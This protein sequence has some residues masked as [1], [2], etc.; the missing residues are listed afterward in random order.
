MEAVPA[1]EETNL[2]QLLAPIRAQ[3]ERSAVLTDVDGTLAPIAPRPED[4]QVPDRAREL[5]RDLARRYAVIGC[6]SGRR[7]LDARR[8]VGLDELSYSG[9]HGFELLSPGEPEPHP[10]PALDGHE[11][12]A[13]AFLERVD[14]ADLERLGIRVEDKGAIVALHW[15]GSENEGEVE[16]YVNDLARRAELG[17]L[18]T[19][20]GRMVLELRPDV[21]IDK[22]RALASLLEGSEVSAALYAGDDRTDLDAFRALAELREQGK[23]EAKVAIAIAAE[24]APQ[25]V[26]AGA[27]LVVPGPEGLIEI[28]EALA[29]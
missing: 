23:L 15:R 18:V 5:L 25:E 6:L 1:G 9:N 12:D 27:D 7:A 10:D 29:A 24:E 4:A 28:L 19:H 2:E 14:R 13:K 20:L 11:G 17:G 22:G 21:S 3:P 8:M 26:V 16:A